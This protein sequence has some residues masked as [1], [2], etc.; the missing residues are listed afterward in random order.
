MDIKKYFRNNRIYLLLILIL[1][2]SF[3]VRIYGLQ[4]ENIWSDE[5]VTIFNSHKSVLHNIKWSLGYG[6][7]PSYHVILSLWEKIFGLKEFNVRFLSLIF[8]IL[9]VYMIFKIGTF[10]FN[11]K[12][13]FYSS[14]ILALSPYNVYY[15]QEARVYALFVF[16][17]LCSIYFYLKLIQ[18]N[19]NKHMVYY[20]L[21][22][23]LM[24]ITHPPAIFILVFQNIHYLF[25]VKKNLKKWVFIQFALFMFFLPLLLRTLSV[26]SGFSGYLTVAPPDIVTLLRTFYIFSAGETFRIEALVIGSFISIG[27]FLL[28]FSVLLQMAKDIKNKYL[29]INKTIFL[30]LWLTIPILLL[31]MQSYVFNSYYFERYVIVSSIALY[32]LIALSITRFN[33]RTQMIIMTSIIILSLMMLYIEFET[34]SNGR[35]K[36]TADYIKANKNENETV[37]IH[38]PNAIYPFAYYFDLECF[39]SYN[40]KKCM[41]MQNI[42]GVNTTKELPVDATNKERVF[43]VLYNIKYVDAEGT[44]LK[45]Y[46][47]NYKLIEEKKYRHIQIFTFNNPISK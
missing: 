43:L 41:S 47:E 30:L 34:N 19:K 12:V 45:Y 1:I 15:S 9:S 21:F 3:F 33:N 23:F 27:F 13:G 24:L 5:A 7:Y 26:I 29:N 17:S 8:G 20:V 2:I 44:L 46:S 4:S 42:Y 31:I 39:K 36:D 32:I 10:M 28:L 37:V 38:H 35:W 6:Y 11:K 25:F 18:S 22:T 16:L 14:I 40:L